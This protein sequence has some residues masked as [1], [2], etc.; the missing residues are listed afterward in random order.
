MSRSRWIK[1]ALAGAL[2]LSAAGGCKQQLFMEPGDY[3]E[4][5][6]VQLPK[7]LE[8]NPH[9]PIAPAKVDNLG[10]DPTT[11]LD[12][13]RPP[14]HMTLRE[15]VAIS[16]EQGNI[17]VQGQQAS[18]FGFKNEALETFTGRAVGGADAVRAFALDPA[19]AQTEIERS[20]SRFDV[21]W[22][23]QMEWDKVD[24]PTAAQFLSFQNSRDVAR[25][26]T[27]LLK[28]LPTG[29]TIG[30]TASTDYSKFS[31]QATSQ[32]ALVNP[33]YTPRITIGVDQPLWQL[34]GVEINQ[35]A[36]TH[37]YTT[38]TS[39]TTSPNGSPFAGVR[40]AGGV[41]SEGILITRIRY[42]Q[43]KANFESQ[44]NFMMVNVEAAYWNLYAAYYNLYAQEEGL[45]QAFEGYRFTYIR[46]LNGTDPPQRLDQIQA[47]FH[48][49][50]SQVYQARAQVLESERQL[51]GLLG[52]RSDDGNRIV[53][54][55]EPNLAPYMPDFHE[56]AN[57][58]ITLRPEL[59]LAR[60]DLMFRSLDLRLQK[61]LRRPDLRGFASYDIAGLG[62]RLGGG[63]FDTNLATGAANPGNA[64][65]DLALNR[66]NSWTI[67]MRLDIPLG[68]RDANGL[69][70]AA[71]LNLARSYIQ[72]RDSELKT[73]EYL[74][75][76][77]RRVIEA[78]A[79]IAP[80]RAEREALQRYV[81][82][83]REVIRIGSWTAQFFLDYLTVQQQL[84]AAVAAESQT[85]ANYN[86]AL[87][88]FEFA[89]G[90][91]QQYNNVSISE[92]PLPPWVSK[93]AADHIRERTE[94]AIK[95]REQPAGP[96][97]PSVSE[98]TISPVGGVNS[99]LKL[100]PFAE[101]HDLL[102]DMLAPN[103]PLPP[104]PNPKIPPAGAVRPAPGTL[105]PLPGVG[106]QPVGT[107]PLPAFGAEGAAG[108]DDY[109]KSDG[110][111]TIPPRP[112]GT[113]PYTG[114]VRQPST[115]TAGG[116]GDY[117]KQDGNVVLPPPPKN[118]NGAPS[119]IPPFSGVGAP[120]GTTN[121][122]GGTGDF[123]PD[124][125]VTLPPPPKRPTGGP[126]W[127]PPG[128]GTPA[129][130]PAPNPAPVPPSIPAPPSVA[131]ALP[132]IP[133]TL[134]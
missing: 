108:A 134:P 6:K 86:T 125:R 69:V 96:V 79:E 10:S 26:S 92:G 94:A 68:F 91:I 99:V 36:S 59:M 17:G 18:N 83:I 7:T 129:P 29:G 44:I 22:V 52:L 67:G 57:D 84:A 114:D 2:T 55:D 47:Q 80:R 128:G 64:F 116:S 24:Q 113:P 97:Q 28:P 9:G 13:V 119:G 87:A 76:Q 103:P 38:S 74:A 41:G 23:T 121:G 122:T 31:Q 50:Q 32:T 8:T 16:L 115:G 35:I 72:L 40:P 27:T 104:A 71:Q 100:P 124:G 1:R 118:L 81:Y 101:K 45:R 131:P 54:I 77:Y 89:K 88:T 30:I 111:V 65:G 132:V 21:R 53:P 58:A 133:S 11:V 43:A 95:L 107:R 109:F 126:V 25:L 48:R 82:R 49:F 33:N 19:I 62:T 63:T 15:C 117:F 66:F 120:T 46:V 61:N 4:A 42:D 93:R 70:R 60:Q 78:H 34:F 3:S 112:P 106:T 14:R 20:L 123:V 102:P 98:S 37:P 73:I 5:L 75:G 12:F 39:F 110:R 56:A 85:I 127:D 105:P 51:R 130:A 90:T